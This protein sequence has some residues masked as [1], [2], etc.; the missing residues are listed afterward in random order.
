MSCIILF[1]FFVILPLFIFFSYIITNVCNARRDFCLFLFVCSIP[2]L[3]IV[4]F[5]ADLDDIKR[6]YKVVFERLKYKIFKL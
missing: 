4:F 1:L 2:F 3:N 5:L 6:E